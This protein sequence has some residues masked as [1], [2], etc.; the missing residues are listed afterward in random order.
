MKKN[1]L[2][3][4]WNEEMVKEVIAHYE[5][6]TDEEAVVEDE[7][8]Y[9]DISQVSMNIPVQLIDA[10]RQLIADYKTQQLKNR[11]KTKRSSYFT[12][13]SPKSSISASMEKKRSNI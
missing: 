11:N 1:N 4:G 9:K 5:E 8:A 12:S 2:P 7:L 13:K 10:V 6:Q 3:Q